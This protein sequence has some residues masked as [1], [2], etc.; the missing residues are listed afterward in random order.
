MFEK[1]YELKYY[2]RIEPFWRRLIFS[3]VEIVTGNLWWVLFLRYVLQG[4]AGVLSL[5]HKVA[6]IAL[7]EG[8]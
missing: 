8:Q 3:G 1:N 7:L 2:I 6:L 5:G 4:L